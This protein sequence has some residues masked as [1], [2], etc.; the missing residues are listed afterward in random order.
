MPWKTDTLERKAPLMELRQRGQMHIPGRTFT[1]REEQM[2]PIFQE[3]C[4]LIYEPA[5]LPQNT[6]IPQAKLPVL[7]SI[8][9]S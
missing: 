9:L 7:K 1:F 8:L 5:L 3:L 6:A 2:I 4:A